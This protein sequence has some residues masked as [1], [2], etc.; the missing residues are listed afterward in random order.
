MLSALFPHG[1]ILVFLLFFGLF[2]LGIIFGYAF[3]KERYSLLASILI[4]FIMS[5]LAYQV[6]GQMVFN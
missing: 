3:K 5:Y 6:M 4:G 2:L 1:V